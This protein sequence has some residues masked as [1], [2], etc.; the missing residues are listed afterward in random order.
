VVSEVEPLT[1]LNLLKDSAERPH[2]PEPVEGSNK[3]EEFVGVGFPGYGGRAGRDGQASDPRIDSTREVFMSKDKKP[4]WSEGRWRDML[5]E[6]RR[7]IWHQDTIEKLANW[8]ELRDGMTAIDVG[9]GLGYLGYTFWP[10]FG[11]NGKYFGVDISEKLLEDAKEASKTWANEGETK[12]L[13]GDAYKLP[14][15]DNFADWVM[16]QT[17][18]M[19]LEKPEAALA[20]MVRVTKPGG[21]IMCNEPDNLSTSLENS[22]TSLPELDID[23]ELLVKKAYI[24]CNKGSIKLGRGDESIG[25]RVG[26]MMKKLGLVEVDVR[27]NDKVIF[28]YPPYDDPR[29]Q[30][31]L[32]MMKK[33]VLDDRQFWM[34]RA[35]EEFLTGGGKPE[36]FEQCRKIWD[37]QMEVLKKQLENGEYVSLFA[38]FFYVIKGRKPK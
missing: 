21:L 5:V 15:E 3:Q 38:A 29:Q 18:L 25:N 23:E 16:C 34:E 26:V 12:F 9:C 2:R 7:F 6:Q 4:D 37:Q 30:A 24:L 31:F 36:E 35:K 8:L 13:Y 19:H 10:Y 11:K 20:E 14:F 17:L 22:Y 33:R 28:L 1:V 32:R 27:M